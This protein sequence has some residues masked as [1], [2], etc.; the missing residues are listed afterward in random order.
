[1]TS[2]EKHRDSREARDA[3]ASDFAQ[4]RE[5]FKALRGDIAA[6]ASSRTKETTESLKERLSKLEAQAEKTFRSAGSELHDLQ[7]QT[8]NAIRK[9]PITTVG[10]ALAVGYFLGGLM[11]RRH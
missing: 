3:M 7:V 9:S 8:E 11:S 2:L 5:D 1:M 4:L 6:L 10:A